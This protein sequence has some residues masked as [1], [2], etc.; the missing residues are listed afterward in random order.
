MGALIHGIFSTAFSY[1][2][3]KTAIFD[4]RRE[5]HQKYLFFLFLM[6]KLDQKSIFPQKFTTFFF[7]SAENGLIS[8]EALTSKKK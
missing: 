5:Y 4:G 2:T 8:N 3:R 1:F 7:Q 6:P